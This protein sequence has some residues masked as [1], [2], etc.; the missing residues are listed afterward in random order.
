MKKVFLAALAVTIG[1]ASCSNDDDAG[2]TNAQNAVVNVK[3]AADTFTKGA[4]D[5]ID[6]GTEIQSAVNVNGKLYIFIAQGANLVVNS[7]MDPEATG[8]TTTSFD[9]AN[10]GSE[11]GKNLTTSVDQVIILANLPTGVDLSTITTVAAL[12][13][14]TNSLEEAQSD[15]IAKK[16]WVQGE[17][18]PQWSPAPDGN[19]VI[20]GTAEVSLHPVLS[21]IDANISIDNSTTG[22]YASLTDFNARADKT[23]GGVVLENVA[24]LYSANTSALVTPFTPTVPTTGPVL[25]SGVIPN[26]G[27]WSQG[28]SGKA[29]ELDPESPLTKET[30]LFA[31]WNGSEWLGSN[32]PNN[33]TPSPA[34][35]YDPA[36]KTFIRSFYAF[37]PKEY[38][39]AKNPGNTYISDTDGYK[40]Y[41]LLTITAKQLDK[42]GADVT[43]RYF[44]VKFAP[45]LTVE[46]GDTDDELLPG[47]RYKA[48]L[49]FKGDFT[50]G[51]GGGTTPEE[52]ESANLAITIQPA[53]W[54][55]AIP[56]NKEFG[57]K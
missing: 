40:A 47:Q 12:Q 38:E 31:E 28:K 11:N 57:P 37:S 6:E 4:F 19:G 55:V 53:K 54:K 49:V 30:F 5:D 46:D 9:K 27:A 23:K 51:G 17:S 42:D 25:S 2:V 32:N 48:N 41:T 10:I 35:N 22:L 33:T 44:S 18:K 3:I 15:Y 50:N 21:R 29:E 45:K 26:G 56:I 39:A 8:S 52:T 16:I 14:V 13:A 1:L 24:I 43:P 34:T 7:S 20:Q 36:T